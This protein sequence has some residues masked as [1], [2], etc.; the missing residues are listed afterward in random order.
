MGQIDRA[1]DSV[2]INSPLPPEMSVAPL[3][4]AIQLG[5]DVKIRFGGSGV[6]LARSWTRSLPSVTI[7]NP[8][9]NAIVSGMFAE[10]PGTL[11]DLSEHDEVFSAPHLLEWSAFNTTKQGQFLRF[12][13]QGG[14]ISNQVSLN[15]PAQ[16]FVS[17]GWREVY[18][19]TTDGEPLGGSFRD[20][21]DAVKAGAD[22]KVRYTQPGGIVWFRTL[23]SVFVS[24]DLDE[25]TTPEDVPVS[26][27]LTDIP[28]SENNPN[29][30]VFSEPFAF[31]WQIFNT[32]GRRQTLTFD[33]QSFTHKNTSVDN[34]SIGW[35][36]RD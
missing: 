12:D 25:A 29:G 15:R 5:A 36:V 2:F 32:T 3:V 23:Q 16:W 21:V 22:V 14:V 31:E 17:F 33:R 10:I 1:W 19:N 13:R 7:T 9:P 27:M 11:R 30:R 28:D 20:L 4:Q 8:G 6:P 24:E 18:Q 35:F 34:L 26:G